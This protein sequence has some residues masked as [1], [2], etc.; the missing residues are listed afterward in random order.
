MLDDFGIC[1]TILLICYTIVFNVQRRSMEQQ[2]TQE[3][4]QHIKH[5][6]ARRTRAQ[7]RHPVRAHSPAVRA[8]HHL[9]ASA[10][11]V[12]CEHTNCRNWTRNCQQFGANAR[13]CSSIARIEERNS[14]LSSLTWNHSPLAL[15][16]SQLGMPV[17]TAA[18]D[19]L[20]EFKLL[21]FLGIV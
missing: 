15:M 14:S 17:R 3:Q 7:P 2:H 11:A 19:P 13:I 5:Q 4:S 20:F 8:Q 18:R 10:A 1:F 9:C 21:I 6:A 16:R 12:P